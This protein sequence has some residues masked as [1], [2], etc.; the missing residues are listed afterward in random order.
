MRHR[1]QRGTD[2]WAGRILTAGF[3]L[4]LA[5][6]PPAAARAAGDYVAAARQYLEKGNSAAAEIELRNAA[7]EA[8]NDPGVH[9]QLGA[10]YLQRGNGAG[11][12][13]EAK[14]AGTLG[15]KEEAYLPLLM[16]ALLRQ[17][18][19]GELLDA[20]P[21]GEREPRL[22]S[23]VREE[24]GLAYTGLRDTDAALASLRDAV[25]LDPQ[26]P[27]PNLALA[28]VLVAAKDITQAGRIVDEV[29]TENPHSAD[30]LQ[31]K[32]QILGLRGDWDG[33]MRNFAAA[34]E[35]DPN[36]AAAHLGRANLYLL[37]QDDVNADKDLTPLLAAAP[38]IR[39]PTICARSS[40]CSTASSRPPASCSTKSARHSPTSST[41]IICRVRSSTSLA[42]WLRPRTI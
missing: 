34:L 8:P 3:L 16:E 35:I 2:R 42:G 18:K 33:A 1:R 32:G 29:L 41:G 40:W 12:A 9:L 17:R 30:A 26:S 6:A 24:R 38:T 14:T 10:L 11:A 7:R 22:E 27:R 20:V 25:R 5:A 31:L 39:R 19:F 13:R 21:A 28:R 37:R 4:A 23:I 15:E 36:N